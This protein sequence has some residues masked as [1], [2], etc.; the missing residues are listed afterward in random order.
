MATKRPT[1]ASRGDDKEI[2]LDLPAWLPRPVQ[3]VAQIKCGEIRGE[4]LEGLQLL[5]RLTSDVRME[6]VWSELLKR[7]RLQHKRTKDFLHPASPF[8]PPNSSW[9][10][11][12]RS[13]RGRAAELQQ[14]G[15][16]RSIQEAKRLEASARV[17]HFLE[18]A[19]L[20]PWYP[21][22]L[23][24][25]AQ[26]LALAFVF[27]Q[28]FELGL[29]TPRSTPSAEA[30]K[31]R[32]RYLDF[33]KRIRCDAAEHSSTADELMAAAFAYEMLA[34]QAAP[35]PGDPLLVER[36]HRSDVV[37]TGFVL[38]LVSTTGAVFGKPLY[39]TVATIANVVFERRDIT[40]ERVRKL[41]TPALKG[42]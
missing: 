23:D 6:R 12:A 14:A 30:R 13:L 21:E 34:D 35:P 27:H 8:D 38:A 32:R 39:G 42:P 15:D 29:R 20:F 3:D 24:W 28:A 4:K 11:A 1:S 16:W 18:M 7:K 37:W 40:G 22:R 31:L 5:R 9:T 36:K 26:D 10:P 25:P 17:S 19:S 33:A 2:T 41:A